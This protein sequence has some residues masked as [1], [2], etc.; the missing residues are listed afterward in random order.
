MV[1]DT[2]KYPLT[3]DDYPKTLLIGSLLVVGT[4]FILPIFILV[5][6]FARAISNAIDGEP[7]PQF[8]AYGE[9]FVD[10]LKLTAISVVYLLGLVVLAA[11]SSLL[12]SI[13]EM[14]GFVGMLVVALYYFGFIYLSTAII[15]QFCRRG[16]MTDAFDLRAIGDTAY[17]L[18][19]FLV[20][21]LW[22]FVLPTL[23]AVGQVLLAVTL[24][25]ILL[26]P[27]TLIYEL[28]V[29]AKLIG[30][31]PGPADTSVDGGADTVGLTGHQ[32]E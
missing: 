20:V 1:V 24:I 29:Y 26:I 5:G 28:V 27:A 3:N 30:D 17:S 19:Y 32:A 12:A 22:L 2:V 18:H 11:L 14:A 15:Y 16:R 4:V 21:L 23:F 7:A 25:G 9:L 13:S 31:L 6:F 10:G 8:S